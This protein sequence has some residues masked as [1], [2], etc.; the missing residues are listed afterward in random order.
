MEIDEQN[1][2]AELYELLLKQEKEI[3]ES[4][5]EIYEA[6]LN[7]PRTEENLDE[8]AIE[9][10]TRQLCVAAASEIMEDYDPLTFNLLKND[11]DAAILL[12][13]NIRETEKCIIYK[14]SLIE[15]LETEISL[16]V[17]LTVSRTNIVYDS[18]CVV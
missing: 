2:Y 18:N 9:I 13:N 16:W 3:S 7:K 14:R 5:R 10:K 6:Q 15:K 8:N 12:E 4:I 1:E 17:F 11:M